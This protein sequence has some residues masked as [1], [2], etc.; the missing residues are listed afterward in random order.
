MGEV[1][2]DAEAVHLADE[3]RPERREAVAARRR[4]RTV[5]VELTR[6]RPSVEGCVIFTNLFWLTVIG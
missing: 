1:D 4:R 6:V 5:L 2:E 3:L